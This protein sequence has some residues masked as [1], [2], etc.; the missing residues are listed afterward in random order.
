M[1]SVFRYVYIVV[2]TL[3]LTETTKESGKKNSLLPVD[4]FIQLLQS[5]QTHIT[6]TSNVIP[7]HLLMQ[8]LFHL[9]VSSVL[10]RPDFLGSYDFIGLKLLTSMSTPAVIRAFPVSFA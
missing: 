9:S 3:N 5:F 10:F 8:P 2:R 6:S 1:F 7:P 4:H